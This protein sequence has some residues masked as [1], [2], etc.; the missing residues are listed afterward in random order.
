MTNSPLRVVWKSHFRVHWCD[1]WFQFH[2][3]VFYLPSQV[4]AITQLCLVGKDGCGT[5]S[6]PV[7]CKQKQNIAL[8][9]WPL[10]IKKQKQTCSSKRKDMSAGTLVAFF[11]SCGLPGCWAEHFWKLHATA[12]R[13]LTSPSGAELPSPVSFTLYSQ[14]TKEW[15][16]CTRLCSTFICWISRPICYAILLLKVAVTER[17]INLPLSFT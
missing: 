9:T 3:L 6:Q 13:S 1:K 10:G 17:H 7:Q 14:L 12:A 8:A 11:T 2:P 5:E 16:T 4:T 15:T